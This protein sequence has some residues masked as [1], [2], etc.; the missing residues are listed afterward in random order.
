MNIKFFKPLLQTLLMFSIA[1]LLNSCNT[2]KN[3]TT[4]ETKSAIYPND[5]IPFM[6]E[7]SILCGDGKNIKDLVNVEHKEFFLCF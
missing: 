4:K 5:V 1:L 2:P 6:D 3:S 7:W